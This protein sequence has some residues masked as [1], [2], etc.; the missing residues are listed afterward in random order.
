M[1]CFSSYPLLLTWKREGLLANAEFQRAK[2][3]IL[4]EEP[5]HE[6]ACMSLGVPRRALASEDMTREGG[7]QSV[8]VFGI[9]LSLDPILVFVFCSFVHTVLRKVLKR[10]CQKVAKVAQRAGPV[11]PVRPDYF[12]LEVFR[13]RPPIKTAR[14]ARAARAR[15]I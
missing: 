10:G 8:R 7:G 11:R 6:Y 14:A 12:F 5:H 13:E 2:E 1:G 3:K 9:W 4:G 15:H